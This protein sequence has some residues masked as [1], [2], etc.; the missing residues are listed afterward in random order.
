MEA[1][2]VCRP[3]SD[4]PQATTLVDVRGRN[5]SDAGSIP[6]ISTEGPQFVGLFF[7]WGMV[8]SLRLRY[9]WAIL[10]GERSWVGKLTEKR[11]LCRKNT[12]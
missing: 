12:V 3:S 8:G 5:L 11:L 6:A 9:R 7:F 10:L 1:L 2:V 4:K